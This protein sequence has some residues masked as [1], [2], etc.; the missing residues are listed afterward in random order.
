[1]AYFPAVS[2]AWVMSD[3]RFMQNIN[4]LNRLKI[5]GS[6]GKSGMLAGQPFQY[7]DAYSLAGNAYA[8]GTGIPV[9]GTSPTN[10]A[11][12]DITWEEAIKTDIGFEAIMFKGLLNLEVDVYK[13]KRSGMLFT[14]STTVPP[15]YG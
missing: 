8:F 11:N 10:Q 12:P 4:F 7:V 5:R 14:P 1:F 2:L 9:Q 15:E 6:W 3:E 13:Q